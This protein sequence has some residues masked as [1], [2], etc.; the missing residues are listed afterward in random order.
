MG[1]GSGFLCLTQYKQLMSSNLEPH[2]RSAAARGIGRMLGNAWIQNCSDITDC[3]SMTLEI[4]FLP[5][6]AWKLQ[7]FTSTAAGMGRKF[8]TQPWK[9]FSTVG[10]HGLFQ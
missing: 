10:T 4:S 6:A 8:P 5:M 7:V 1:G 3:L 9:S 2:T